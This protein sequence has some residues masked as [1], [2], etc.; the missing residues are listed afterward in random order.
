MYVGYQ[1]LAKVS[2]NCSHVEMSMTCAWRSLDLE[3]RYASGDTLRYLAASGHF[4]A[5]DH[6]I[7]VALIMAGTDLTLH[8]ETDR[9]ATLSK[10]RTHPFEEVLRN[11]SRKPYLVSP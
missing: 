11:T 6:L 3:Y 7:L 4:A 8:F 9:M 1:V 10:S 5:A 2:I